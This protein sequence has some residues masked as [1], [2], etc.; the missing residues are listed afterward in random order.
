MFKFSWWN[1][2]HASAACLT[3]SMV[4]TNL[5][6]SWDIVRSLLRNTRSVG[7]MKSRKS[8]VSHLCLALTSHQPP[9]QCH[10]PAAAGVSLQAW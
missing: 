6:E 5:R 1:C 8:F 9:C 7:L 10:R 4:A 3:I 2:P